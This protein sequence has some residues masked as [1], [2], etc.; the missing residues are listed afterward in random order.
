MESNVRKNVTYESDAMKS[1]AGLFGPS[2]ATKATREGT[3][4]LLETR[5]LAFHG[6]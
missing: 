3:G 5:K 6:N 4:V 2:F 1:E